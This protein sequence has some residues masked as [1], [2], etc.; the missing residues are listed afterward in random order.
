MRNTPDPESSN[1][2][3]QSRGRRQGAIRPANDPILGE[4]GVAGGEAF[5]SGCRLIPYRL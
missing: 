5:H 1:L 3:R 2:G 4:K